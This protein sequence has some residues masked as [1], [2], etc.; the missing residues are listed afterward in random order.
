MVT[1]CSGGAAGGL[2]SARLRVSAASERPTS[3]MVPPITSR[4][5]CMVP[6]LQKELPSEPRFIYSSFEQ[7]RIRRVPTCCSNL[8][9]NRYD[10]STIIE[11]YVTKKL[12]RLLHPHLQAT[13]A[14]CFP[15]ARRSSSAA[16][17]SSTSRRTSHWRY[18]PSRCDSTR[19]ARTNSL[20]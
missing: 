13:E 19:P 12:P 4:R 7:P 1:A 17:A 2:S 9:H 8:L 18:W 5:V 11:L 15:P 14:L 6:C 16:Y 3:P 10:S 20:M